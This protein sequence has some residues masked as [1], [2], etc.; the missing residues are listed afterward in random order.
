VLHLVI[1]VY[2]SRGVRVAALMFLAL[3]EAESAQFAFQ[4]GPRDMAA[5]R[6]LNRRHCKAVRWSTLEEAKAKLQFYK[7]MQKEAVAACWNCYRI[8]VLA[9]GISVSLCTL[10]GLYQLSHGTRPNSKCTGIQQLAQ[11]QMIK[12]HTMLHDVDCRSATDT[13]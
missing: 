4:Q 12:I 11:Q 5:R 2:T 8:E 9:V 10:Q 13:Y 7:R 3:D 1:T 6:F